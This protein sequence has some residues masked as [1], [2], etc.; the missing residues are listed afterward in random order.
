MGLY[1]KYNKSKY[2]LPRNNFLK[3]VENVYNKNIF[4]IGNVYDF[5]KGSITPF[6]KSLFNWLVSTGLKSD[7]EC[8][9]LEIDKEHFHKN[10]QSPRFYFKTLEEERK[11]KEEL[12]MSEMGRAKDREKYKEEEIPTEACQIISSTK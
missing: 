2:F 1:K 11:I 4:V 7:I 6:Y 10:R 12:E 8:D 9:D 5:Y 3:I